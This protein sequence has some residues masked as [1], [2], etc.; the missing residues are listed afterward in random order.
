MKDNHLSLALCILYKQNI[1]MSCSGTQTLVYFKIAFGIPFQL[2]TSCDTSPVHS[3]TKTFHSFYGT[4]LMHQLTM[5]PGLALL[6]Y[7]FVMFYQSN[8][9]PKSCCTKFMFYQ[10]YV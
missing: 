5:G 6:I 4:L 7:I 9:L 3:T 1:V 8:V 10:I 2:A